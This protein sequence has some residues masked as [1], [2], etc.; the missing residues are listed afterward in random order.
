[1]YQGA[2][3]G[4][5]EHSWGKGSRGIKHGSVKSLGCQSLKTIYQQAFDTLKKMNLGDKDRNLEAH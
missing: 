4:P 5:R 2:I 1:M 3:G